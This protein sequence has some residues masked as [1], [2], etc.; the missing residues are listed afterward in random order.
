MQCVFCKSDNLKEQVHSAGCE[1]RFGCLDCNKWQTP[2]LLKGE[3]Y[4]DAKGHYFGI[5]R[6]ND[7]LRAELAAAK[8]RVKDLEAEL[9]RIA[10]LNGV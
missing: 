4:T 2:L 3:S 8:G 9:C 10:R 7:Q 1:P 5:A 6:E